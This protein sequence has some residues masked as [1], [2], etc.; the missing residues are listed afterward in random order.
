MFSIRMRAGAKEHHISGA[1]R[2][3]E[4]ADLSL[5]AQELVQRAVTHER[6]MPET[7]HITIEKIREEPCRIPA[8]PIT[9]IRTTCMREARC[10]AAAALARLGIPLQVVERSLSLLYQG[11]AP[12]GG[13]MRGAVVMESS[14]GRRLEPDS[15]RGVRATRLDMSL[16]AV[17]MLR[18]ELSRIHLEERFEIIR[19][20][21]VLASK[22]A[23]GVTLAEVCISDNPSNH[24]GYVASEELGFLRIPYLKQPG[25]PVGG[26]IFYVPPATDID[27]YIEY[28][29]HTPVIVDCTGGARIIT[30][31][32]FLEELGN[33]LPASQTTH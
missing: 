13:C 12:D 28:L 4:V 23:A 26:R 1:E 15:Y 27:G 6:G 18:E 19:E 17:E 5:L 2:I 10:V 25:S 29:E 32:G 3:A 9:S 22:V 21:L 16:G 31:S 11:P 7:I 8:L 14:T 20:A 30:V 33:M 24:T